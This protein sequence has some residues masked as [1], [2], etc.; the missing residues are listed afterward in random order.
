MSS[1]L[2]DGGTTNNNPEKLGTL[3][4]I[5]NTLLENDITCASF[6]EEDLGDQM[7]S[8]CFLVDERVFNR[9]KYLDLGDWVVE[10]Y[11]D[12]IKGDHRIGFN[13]NRL[14]R[15]IK[16]SEIPLEKKIY[17]N[18]VE[19]IGGEKNVFLKEFLAPNKFGLA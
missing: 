9:K 7:T 10:N 3:N 16:N 17:Q 12:L 14:E 11:G 18:W 1:R 5:Y 8:I 19:Y 2:L 4:Q 6:C 15:D 13:L